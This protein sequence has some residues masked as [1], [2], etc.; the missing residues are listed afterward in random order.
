MAAAHAPDLVLRVGDLP[1][2]KPLRAWLAGLDDALQVAFDPEA[3][4]QDPDAALVATIAGA[5]PRDARRADAAR[6]DRAGWTAWRAADRAAAR[7]IAE[8][9]RRRA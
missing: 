4:W 3:A 7:A 8:V 9:A 6:R 1:T 5:D 2:S